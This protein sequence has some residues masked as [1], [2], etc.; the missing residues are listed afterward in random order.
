MYIRNPIRQR[1]GA[2]GDTMIEQGSLCVFNFQSTGIK[3][4]HPES[5]LEQIPGIVVRKVDYPDSFLGLFGNTL[6]IT[7]TWNGG[8]IGA[9]ALGA[10][11]AKAL[12]EGWVGNFKF[13][14]GTGE[15]GSTGV[16]NP[17][18]DVP[19]GV[20]LGGAGALLGVVLI[21]RML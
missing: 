3:P 6:R 19:W 12:S 10:Y 1:L 11:M 21:K 20:I 8:R 16:P 7:F 17:P 14:G 9:D 15:A 4:I 18:V 5:R 2:L 13:V